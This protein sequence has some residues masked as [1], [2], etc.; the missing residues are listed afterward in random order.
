MVI[1]RK[2]ILWFETTALYWRHKY[3]SKCSELYYLELENQRLKYQLDKQIYDYSKDPLIG[4]F[5]RMR[6]FHRD[7]DKK[8]KS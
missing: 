3:Y 6:S 4:D 1:I 8:A 7:L 2:L 5:V